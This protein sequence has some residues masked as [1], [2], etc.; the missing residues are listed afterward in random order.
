MVRWACE[1][2]H[3]SSWSFIFRWI[4][5]RCW[6]N[7]MSFMVIWSRYDQD[8]S[9]RLKP[10]VSFMRWFEDPS[11]CFR[12]GWPCNDAWFWI[13]SKTLDPL[14]LQ[15]VQP[16]HSKQGKPRV[17]R[18]Q[19]VAGSCHV[20]RQTSFRAH[21]IMKLSE[22]CIGTYW[23]CMD[24]TCVYIAFIAFIRFQRWFECAT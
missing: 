14:A 4:I 21:L 7:M 18:L 13:G 23:N 5:E 8:E 6:E 17:N 10:E 3:G 24:K 20:W 15:S 12:S 19:G 1:W 9:Q 11:A 2:C 16:L 22:C